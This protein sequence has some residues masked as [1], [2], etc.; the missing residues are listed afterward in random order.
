[1][2]TRFSDTVSC[3]QDTSPIAYHKCQSASEAND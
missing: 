3:F 1:M 2:S